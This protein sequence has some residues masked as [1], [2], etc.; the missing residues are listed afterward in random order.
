MDE[1]PENGQIIGTVSGST[2]EGSVTFSITEQIPSGAFSIDAASGDLSVADG[3]LFSFETN[4]VITG[5]IRVAN[6]DI[7]KNAALTITLNALENIYDGNF[8]VRTQEEVNVFGANQYTEITGSFVIGDP[9]EGTTTDIYDLS[10]LHSLRSIN[11]TL[12]ISNNPLLIAT[13]GLNIEHVGGQLAFMYNPSLEKI[14]GFNNLTSLQ[15]LFIYYNEALSNLSSFSQIS[16]IEMY[17]SITSCPLIPNLDWLN[18]LTTIGNDLSVRFCNSITD[19]DGLSNLRNFDGENFSIQFTNNNTLENLNGLRNLNTTINSLS[20]TDNPSLLNIDGLEN[21]NVLYDVGVSFNDMLLDLNG[22]RTITSLINGIVIA[23]NNSLLDLRGL[24]NL[25][26]AGGEI[27]IK[28]NTA[29]TSLNG[30]EAL[31]DFFLIKVYDN[32]SLIDFCA[33][34]NALINTPYRFNAM[35]NAFNPSGQDILD[36][37]CRL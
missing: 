31:S 21:I 5:N 4:P 8:I 16:S 18:G 24:D 6:G 3:T 25:T 28:E 17:L 26:S 14:E 37:N 2:N 34:Q 33:L 20:I 36:G 30:L 15:S 19:V 29:L 1:H 23:K 11:G 7:F 27:M 9:E 13:S 32:S 22:L 10:P 12:N 35:R